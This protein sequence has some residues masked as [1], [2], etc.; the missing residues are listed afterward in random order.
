M[1]SPAQWSQRLR[2]MAVG[3]VGVVLGLLAAWAAPTPARA[4]LVLGVQSVTVFENSTQNGLEVTLTNTGA[5]AVQISAF[6][7]GFSVVSPN[8][9]FRDVTTATTTPYIFAGRSFFGPSIVE[10]GSLPGQVGVVS[11]LYDI[12]NSAITL[13]SGGAVGLGYLI[14]DAGA[15]L[16]EFTVE[17]TAPPV[18]SVSNGEI[19]YADGELVRQGGTITVRAVP[20]PGSLML[21]I[22]GCAGLALTVRHRRWRRHGSN[23]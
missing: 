21:A 12:P 14:F 23:G 5:S 9:T 18:T 17:L 15:L 8:I 16:G 4:E 19:P 3:P 11:D 7:F 2:R 20:E 1:S 6:A 13:V 22:S 10:P